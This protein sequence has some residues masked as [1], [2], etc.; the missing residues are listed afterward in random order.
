MKNV[1]KELGH[2]LLMDS[3]RDT[4]KS[5]TEITP[6]TENRAEIVSSTSL[7]FDLVTENY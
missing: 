3:W 2:V 4:C 7:V 6:D 1:N 5:Q